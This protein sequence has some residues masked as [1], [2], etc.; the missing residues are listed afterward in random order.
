[1]TILQLADSVAVELGFAH[2][3]AR[4]NRTS[5]L[6]NAKLAVDK[7]KGRMLS[8]DYMG[9]IR[10]SS[11]M[12]QTAMVDV[13]IHEAD[14]VIPWDC[15][16]FDLPAELYSLPY[17]GGLAW[18][19]YLRNNL[20][21][22]CT[23][24]IARVPFSHTTLGSLSALYGMAYQAPSAASPY[25]ARDKYRVYVF[26]VDR[27]IKTLHVGFFAALPNLENMDPNEQIDL[28]PEY[29][30]AAKKLILDASRFSLQL[31]ERLRNDGRDL[32]PDQPL[33]TERPVS[34]NDPLNIEQL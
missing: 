34:V 26:G 24:Q 4:L 27:Q 31:P 9:D 13:V 29:L 7:I 21:P 30:M 12:L 14:N 33:R 19:R 8:K 17:D 18:V 10:Q 28:P 11:D 32:D 6:F 16:Y 20:P 25:V 22:N 1:M 3:D 15:M 2:D 5:M 23:P